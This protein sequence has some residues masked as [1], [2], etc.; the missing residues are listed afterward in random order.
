MAD[1]TPEQIAIRRVRCTASTLPAFLGYSPYES[2]LT[3]WE[4]HLGIGGLPSNEN[5]DAGHDFE[6]AIIRR[7]SSMIDKYRQSMGAMT[8]ISPSHDWLCATPDAIIP[9][10]TTGIQAK[11]HGAQMT[12]AYVAKPGEA[13]E[14]D[15]E[16]VPKMYLLQCQIEMFV[17]ADFYGWDVLFWYLAAHFG[18]AQTRVYKIRRDERLQAA[19]LKAGYAFWKLH[20]DPAGKRVPPGSVQWIVGPEPRQSKHPRLNRTALLHAPLPEV[21]E[22]PASELMDFD[23]PFGEST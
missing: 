7:A 8:I 22:K 11:N 12:R 19:L 17:A 3:A 21:G 6:A 14:W 18:G 13:G 15:N 4:R 10:L 23:D 9:E 1:L 5:M 20:I 2:P 16:L